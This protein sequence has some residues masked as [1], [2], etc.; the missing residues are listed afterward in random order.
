MKETHNINNGF[1]I[2][3]H[4]R[5]HFTWRWQMLFIILHQRF[6]SVYPSQL[7]DRAYFSRRTLSC[8]CVVIHAALSNQERRKSKWTENMKTK[9][10]IQSWSVNLNVPWNGCNTSVQTPFAQDWFTIYQHAP[11]PTKH[12]CYTSTRQLHRVGGLC[13]LWS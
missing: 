12:R 5:L 2:Y 7:I 8:L 13:V 9:R 6:S 11:G 4:S 1:S 3:E 10:S